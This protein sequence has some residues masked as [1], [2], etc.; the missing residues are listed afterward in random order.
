[1]IPK[2]N[3]HSRASHFR[4]IMLLPSVFKRLHA[5]LRARVIEVIEPIKPAGQIG[6]FP[7]QQVQFGAMSL[8]CLSRLAQ[9]HQLSFGVVFVDLA[10]A[11]HRLI[12]ELVCGI[13]RQDDVEQLI[14][15]L[16]TAPCSSRGVQRWLELPC[17]LK[18]LGAPDGSY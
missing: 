4:G 14:A 11:F 9:Y 17:L 1:M 10:N 16:Q 6:G 5:L 2:K 18:R 8:Q 7:G 15:A 3:D 12:R 13:T